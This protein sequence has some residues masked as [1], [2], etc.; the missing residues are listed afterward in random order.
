MS[1]KIT[2]NENGPIKV[3]GDFQILDAQGDIYDTAG[4]PAVFLCRCGQTAR[5]PFCDGAH[6]ACKFTSPSKAT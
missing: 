1:A 5:S 6:K 2:I 4:K 3:E